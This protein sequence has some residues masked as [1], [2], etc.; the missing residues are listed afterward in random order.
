MKA[1]ATDPDALYTYALTVFESQAQ[2]LEAAEEALNL[3]VTQVN[4]DALE[5]DQKIQVKGWH[6]G[7]QDAV[8]SIRGND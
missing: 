6:L 4:W 3:I 2:A 7:L 8:K 1:L 5:P